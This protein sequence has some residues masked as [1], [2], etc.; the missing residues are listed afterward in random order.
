MSFLDIISGAFGVI[1][2]V[3]V[4]S[5][6]AEPMVIEGIR[7]NLDGVIAELERTIFEMRGEVTV[8]NREKNAK[9]VELERDQIELEGFE[10]ELRAVRGQYASA[11]QTLEA[12]LIIE[13]K[14]ASARQDLTE[15]MRRLLGESF[16][17]PETDS[18]IGGVPVDSEYIIFIVDTSGSM[19]NNAWALVI[20][21]VSE[22]LKI[23]PKVK[24]IQVM[25][26][27]GDY[28]FSTY[29]GR[30][31]P[32]TPSRRKAILKRLRT[33]SPFSNSSPVEGITRAIR[34]FYAAD[35]K[36]SLYVF[37]DEFS[38]PSID[39]V[40]KQ[41]D[42]INKEDAEGNRLVRIHG[43]G[44]PVQLSRPLQL[45]GTGIRFAALMRILSNR[46]GGTFVAL[47]SF[48]P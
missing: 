27:M 10:K 8:L 18:N 21:K 47:D 6:Q 42:A 36:I 2:L 31:I 22:T 41:V 24:G 44:F 32:D 15:E 3:F 19:F 37:G 39:A 26:D 17:R 28:M 30:W 20:R 12:K 23:Y 45:Q 33:W 16:R 25:N 14:L 4:L 40:V 29:A 48:K 1:I 13:G 9:R 43:V 35:K 5:K 34:T 7:E 38:G 46:N 11:E